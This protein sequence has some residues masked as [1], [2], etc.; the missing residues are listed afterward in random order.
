VATASAAYRAL[1]GRCAAAPVRS[2][3]RRHPERTTLHAVVR[4]QLESFL[5]R[6]RENRHPVAHK[7]LAC[8]DLPAR[9]PPL[10]P[11]SGAPT[12]QESRT[13]GADAARAFD[14]TPPDDDGMA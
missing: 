13:W 2:Y 7:I 1:P 11:A 5:M 6:A 12:W 10:S 8:L 14:Q 9:A 4:E 3:E